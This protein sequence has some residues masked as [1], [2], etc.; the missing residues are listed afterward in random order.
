MEVNSIA[1]GATAPAGGRG[2]GAGARAGVFGRA[3]PMRWLRWARHAPDRWLHP[4]R[5]RRASRRLRSDARP[6]RV[7]FVCQGNI[8][9]S[10]Y[11]AELFAS[12]RPGADSSSAGFVG[13]DRGCP[14]EAV[15]VAARRGV[16]LGAHLSRLLTAEMVRSTDLVVVM[17]AAQRAALRAR[18][19]GGAA[20]V[21]VLGDL[22]PEPIETR[23]ITDPWSRSPEVL[24]ACYGRIERCVRSLA[25]TIP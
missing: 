4:W 7:L 16:G 5:R 13:P 23:A 8:Y 10:P 1:G 19:G 12:A 2:A 15:E 14:P 9:R 18:F 22:D 6:R 25:R 11:A 20:R 17:D 3:L 21:L 24:E